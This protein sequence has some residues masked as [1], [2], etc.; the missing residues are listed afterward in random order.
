MLSTFFFCSMPTFCKQDTF[1]TIA[2]NQF[3]QYSDTLVSAAGTFEAGFFNFGDSQRQYF[4]DSQ[5]WIFV[6]HIGFLLL[7]GFSNFNLTFM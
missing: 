3:M 7:A 5:V 4:G 1:T 6:I 2:P